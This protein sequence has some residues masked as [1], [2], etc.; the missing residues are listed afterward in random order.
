MKQVTL[1]CIV[2]T[3]MATSCIKDEPANAEADIIRVVV[4]VEILKREPIIQNNSVTFMVKPSVDLT[5]QAPEFIL[6]DGA[7]IDPTSGTTRDFTL[8]QSY[9][10]TSENG[11]WSKSYIVS[12]ISS[13][14]PTYYSFEDTLVTLQSKGD[15]FILAE[16]SNGE[17]EW[18]SGNPGFRLTGVAKPENKGTDYP[19]F[20]EEGGVV[21]KCAKLVTRSTGFFG[22]IAGMPIAAGNLFIGTFDV[23]SAL[24]DPLKATQFGLP[25]YNL[26]RKLT[27]YYKYKAGTTFLVN[28][29]AVS[30]RSD[31]FTIYAML[32]EATEEVRTLDG[33]FK[34]NGYQDPNLIAL[35]MIDDAQESE[36][37]R[38]FEIPFNYDE[39]K[40][41]SLT[42]LMAGVYNIGIVFTSSID[43]DIFEGAL[44]STLWIDEVELIYND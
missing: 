44:E 36:E 28:G 1:L 16:S 24:K 19:T 6:T 18:A 31:M 39:N 10:V 3:C 11:L 22:S 21:G 27:G 38:R 25:F 32:Y 23:S 15:Y 9:T 12:Y 41:I 37:W 8:P 13:E 29:T 5:E 14:I 26:P 30:G 43:G 2:F 20:Q 42:K 34:A 35:A 4:P 33:N 7:T 40:S 17:M